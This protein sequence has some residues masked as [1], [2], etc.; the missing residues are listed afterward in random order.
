MGKALRAAKTRITAKRIGERTERHASVLA[1]QFDQPPVDVIERGHLAE[2]LTP[3]GIAHVH[4]RSRSA[5]F[6]T[7][8]AA[9]SGSA[10]RNS[11][12]R[13]TL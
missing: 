10:S 12:L 9:F 5:V 6:S 2:A 8:P 13:G 4:V 3:C 1:Q 11:T 7:L